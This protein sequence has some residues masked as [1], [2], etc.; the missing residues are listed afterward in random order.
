LIPEKIRNQT[1]AGKGLMLE[2]KGNALQEAK[3]RWEFVRGV[4]DVRPEEHVG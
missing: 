3:S 1:D 4:S 2:Q